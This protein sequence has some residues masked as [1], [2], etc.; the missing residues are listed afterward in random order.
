MEEYIN[1]N[2]VPKL[3]EKILPITEDYI[4]LNKVPKLDE[5]ILPI[6]EDLC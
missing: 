6:T 5:K 1:L 4:N 3:D 2:K